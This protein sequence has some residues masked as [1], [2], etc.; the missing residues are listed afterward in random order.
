MYDMIFLTGPWSK[1]VDEQAI[2][3][4]S[5]VQYILIVLGWLTW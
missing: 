4:P 2:A 5:E 3:K 1:F